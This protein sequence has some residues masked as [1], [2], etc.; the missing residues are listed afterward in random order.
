MSVV[1]HGTMVCAL[2]GISG[3]KDVEPYLKNG[4][5]A[6]LVGEAL[7]RAKDTVAFISELLGGEEKG[8]EHAQSEEP[9]VKICG[10]RSGAAAK[11]AIEA[12]ADMI[13]IILVTGRKRFVSTGTA[14]E[15]SKA[16]HET[17]KARSKIKQDQSKQS[18]K[19]AKNY[20]D[21][22]AQHLSHPDRALLVGVFQD[23][24]L[25]YILE[26]QKL[27]NLDIVQLHGSEPVEWARQIPVP[28]IKTFKPNNTGIGITGYHVSSLLDSGIGGTGTQLDMKDLQTCLTKDGN[29]RVM[30]AGGLNPH[31]VANVL[32]SLG[33]MSERVIGVDVSSGVEEDGQQSFEKIREFV[34]A[35][36]SARQ[37]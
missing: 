25:E 31:N 7:M 8:V 9:L 20:F 33:E 23:H 14:L 19:T 29:I 13:G 1:P 28:V 18:S 5:G 34:N 30:L 10:T 6:V 36:K 24:P 37:A 26:Q 11:V 35:A 21:H 22:S 27:L 17:R 3:P 32:E 4:V 2:S 15:I 16:V 12:G